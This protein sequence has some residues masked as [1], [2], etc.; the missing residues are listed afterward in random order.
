MGKKVYYDI[1]DIWTASYHEKSLNRGGESEFCSYALTKIGDEF[2][3]FY[4]DDDGNEYVSK[5]FTSERILSTRSKEISS[6]DPKEIDE[7]SSHFI[8][9]MANEEENK[10]KRLVYLTDLQNFGDFLR[11]FG[12]DINSLEEITLPRA[13]HIMSD[14]H[15]GGVKQNIIND[16]LKIKSPVIKHGTVSFIAMNDTMKNEVLKEL[17]DA[18]EKGTYKVDPSFFGLK[19]KSLLKRLVD[20]LKN[21]HKYK[22]IDEGESG[23]DG[24]ARIESIKDDLKIDGKPVAPQNSPNIQDDKPIKEDDPKNKDI[25]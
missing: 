1:S 16:F 2:Y 5:S 14:F 17:F 7:H 18:V 12:I 24:K 15:Y 9:E 25:R 21:R 13:E 3:H 19:R 10:D 4:Y 22:L 6:I 20:K 11:Q 23:S 8:V